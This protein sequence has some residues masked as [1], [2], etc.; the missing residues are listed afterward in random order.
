MKKLNLLFGFL[1]GLT[2]LACSSDNNDSDTNESTIIGEWIL[3]NQIYDG[4]NE[5]LSACELQESLT[6][7]SDGTLISYYTDNDSSQKL[8]S[9]SLAKTN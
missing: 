1:I 7:N 5:S 6:F 3:V 8:N 9:M 2:I 4:Q